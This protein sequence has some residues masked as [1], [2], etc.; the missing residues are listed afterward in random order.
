MSLSIP[1][2]WH[3]YG[4]PRGL[5]EVFKCRIEVG[6]VQVVVESKEDEIGA[7]ISSLNSVRTRQNGKVRS[8][9]NLLHKH[10]TLYC[11]QPS[12]AFH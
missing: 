3:D 11:L 5:R 9:V 8:Q 10:R 2:H 1:I 7:Q 12:S 6:S 4:I